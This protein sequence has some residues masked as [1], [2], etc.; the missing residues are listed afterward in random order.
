MFLVP[1]I[2]YSMQY[3]SLLTEKNILTLSKQRIIQKN[4]VHFQG[5]PDSLYDKQLLLSPE[6][7]GQYGNIIKIVLVS[8]EDK[9][10]K[11]KTNSAYL[12]FETKEQAAYCILSVDSFKIGNFMVRAF[13]GTTKY[14]THFLNN[15]LCFNEEKCMF[16]HHIAEASDIINE[17]TKFGYSDHIKLAKKIVGY[18][19]FESKSYVMNNCSKIKT[20]LPNI[21]NLY[22]KEEI[23]YTKIIKNN[24]HRR[25]ISNSSNNSTENNSFNRSNN[26]TN[27]LSPSKNEASKTN[28]SENNSL[29]KIKFENNNI[30]KD[31]NN[32]NNT[33][34]IC[35][36]SGNKSRFFNNNVCNSNKGY[37]SKNITYI[38]D[39]LF[40]RNLYFN[41]YKNNKQ[42]PSLK[43]LEYK[44]CLKIYEKTND[45]DI[46]LL[47]ENKF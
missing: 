47:L 12:T 40:K 10:F 25:N 7:F 19:S 23:I 4:L 35:F 33:N 32:N 39:N 30:L 45:N 21:K 41:K 18:G 24:N 15:Y 28:S 26:R 20:V 36:K 34:F 9:I 42:L 44:Y 5:F 6:Y 17:N 27:S 1:N 37:E 16:L 38:I 3:T 11:K 8:K 14:C 31:G 46:K 22:Y 2:P 13:F 29:E 43:E